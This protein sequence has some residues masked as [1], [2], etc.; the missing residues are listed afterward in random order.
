MADIVL[1]ENGGQT[2]LVTGDKYIDDLLAGTLPA[3]ITIE[4]VACD[5]YTEIDRL[6]SESGGANAGVDAPWLINPAIVAR[7]RGTTEQRVAFTQ[8][9][10][11]L[12]E[13]ARETIR[14]FAACATEIAS[15]EVV[16]VSYLAA[17]SAALH[18]DLANLRSAVIEAELTNLGVAS[19]RIVR[20]SRPVTNAET[21]AAETQRIDILLNRQ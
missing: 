9:S 17:D 11:Q 3:Q 4:F 8:W 5:S 14:R 7:I 10:A 15:A 1:A 21:T 2:W 18:I 12:D 6:W 13:I 16:L 20:A 19:S